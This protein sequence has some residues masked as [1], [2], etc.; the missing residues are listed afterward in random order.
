MEATGYVQV[1]TARSL[2]SR[3]KGRT[4]WVSVIRQCLE[5]D[6][7]LREMLI[8]YGIFGF[9]FFYLLLKLFQCILL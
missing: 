8:I 5:A 3:N 7:S 6:E 4:S 9:S 2:S 1:P